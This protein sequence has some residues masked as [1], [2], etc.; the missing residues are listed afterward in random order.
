MT[1]AAAN[2][3][4]LFG[5]PLWEDYMDITGGCFITQPRV[6]NGTEM[7]PSGWRTPVPHRLSVIAPD[8]PVTAG[9]PES[10]KEDSQFYAIWQVDECLQY[11]PSDWM[12]DPVGMAGDIDAVVELALDQV[13]AGNVFLGGHS[14]GTGFT[15][16][17][18]NANVPSRARCT[19]S[20]VTGCVQ[21]LFSRRHLC[22]VVVNFFHLSLHRNCRRNL[23]H[24]PG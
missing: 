23:N 15:Q 10:C 6:I 2:P 16:V 21:R 14:A 17:S 7:P 4:A 20:G 11:M 9:L 18:P 22:P 19:S 3:H 1:N 8:H 24:L 5:W 12:F 13:G